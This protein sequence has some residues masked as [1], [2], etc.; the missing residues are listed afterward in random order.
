MVDSQLLS[1]VKQQK[2]A[3][4]SSAELRGI[5]LKQGYSAS[6]IN[7]ALRGGTAPKKHH[8]LFVVAGLVVVIVIVLAYF[9]IS[10]PGVPGQ[11]L[12][13]ETEAITSDVVAGDELSF[14]IELMNL[15]NER[16]YDVFLTHTVV[17]EGGDE[18]ASKEE[19]VAI[20]TRASKTSRIPL[21]RNLASGT[22]H[23]KTI[24]RYNGD[25]AD[26][27][28][29]FSLTQLGE[30]IP[31]PIVTP[32]RS[33]QP[34]SAL[35]PS[36]RPTELDDIHELALTNRDLALELCVEEFSEQSLRDDCHLEIALTIDDGLVCGRIEESD[37]RDNCYVNIV[38]NK[39]D[40]SLCTKIQDQTLRNGCLSL[41]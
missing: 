5:L 15:G 31:T 39:N 11:L 22:Y 37:K 32:S 2:Q 17:D 10:K 34:S 20:E 27:S 19:S 13:V 8:F 29:A 24:A 33:T 28:F 38:L 9:L 14:T 7:E 12:D 25:Q 3:G 36:L 16:R 26:A 40:F 35:A 41:S 6:Q 1:Y 21:P 4:Y 18:V 23:V 30:T